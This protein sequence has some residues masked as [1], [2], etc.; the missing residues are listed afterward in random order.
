MPRAALYRTARNWESQVDPRDQ[1][2]YTNL[3]DEISFHADLRFCD[4]VQ[5]SHAT[6]FFAQ[7]SAWLRNVP[8]VRYQ[9]ALLELIAHLIFIDRAQ[10]TSLYRDAFRKIISPWL[11]E[12]SWT[13]DDMLRPDY[14]NQQLRALAQFQFA[15]VT[16]SCDVGLL[17][18]TNDLHGLARP[19]VLGPSVQTARSLINGLPKELNGLIV[20]EDIVGTG[21]QARR[22]LH[23]TEEL[24]EPS[25]RLLF[26]PLIA[27]ETGLT[28]LASAYLQRTSVRPVITLPKRHCV[29]KHPSSEEPDLFKFVR[30]IVKNTARRVLE[31]LDDLDDPPL[32]AFGYEDS[33]GLV[34]TCHNS[35]NNTLPLIHHQSPTWT[36]LFRRLHHK[37]RK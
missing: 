19:V 7:L 3:L 17:L 21:K 35:P 18:K 12:Q 5:Y 15:S 8:Q 33:G 26:V 1:C 31:P 10:M 29:R 36:A 16:E 37:E 9:K 34:V 6:S 25:W 24:A 30:G 28:N 11:N 20:C 13:V 4:Y 32:D 2:D 27:F 14:R 22:I 23:A